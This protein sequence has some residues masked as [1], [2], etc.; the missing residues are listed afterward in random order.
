[1]F[2]LTGGFC[3]F[4]FKGSFMIRSIFFK[5]LAGSFLVLILNG[6]FLSACSEDSPAD[7]PPVVEG[8]FAIEFK[9]VDTNGDTVKTLVDEWSSA[10]QQYVMWNGRDNDDVLQNSGVFTLQMRVYSDETT[11][12]FADSSGVLLGQPDSDMFMATTDSRGSIILD[13]IRLF[14]QLL[15]L[16]DM[17]ATDENGDALGSFNVNDTMHALFRGS[18]RNDHGSRNIDYWRKHN[19]GQLCVEP[20]KGNF[21]RGPTNH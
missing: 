5:S 2:N 20:G 21:G 9:V 11:L 6:L 1:M 3:E 10:G 16:P 8:E 14:P 18:C 19:P 4:N 13:D 17:I 7:I 15:N 12:S